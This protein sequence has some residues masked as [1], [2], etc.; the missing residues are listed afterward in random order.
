MFAVGLL[1][2]GM[3]STAVGCYSGAEVMDG[4]LDVRV[5]RC[6]GARHRRPGRRGARA[7]AR[8]TTVLLASQ[9]V[10]SFGIPFALVPLVRLTAQR[11]V[12]GDEVNRTGTTVLAVICCAVIVGLNAV[13]LTLFFGG[14]A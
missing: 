13:L 12:M 1:V 3:A 4:L 6:Y 9:V 14:I 8:A 7:G 5:A 10:L 2:S 11:Q